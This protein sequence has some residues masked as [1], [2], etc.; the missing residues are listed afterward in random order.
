MVVTKEEIR[1]LLNKLQNDPNN[2]FDFDYLSDKEKNPFEWKAILEGSQGSIYENGY[3]M[4]KIVF[5][6]SYPSSCPSVYF[7]NKIFHPHIH[8]SGTACIHPE[9]N[10]ILSVMECVENMF[11]YYDADLNHA[12]GEEPRTTLERNKEEFI[13]KAQEWVRQYA[14]LEDL[15]KFYDL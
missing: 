2:R 1:T 10:D 7:L 9:R 6:E 4:V 3:Y 12:Y 13:K 11:F 14:K 8:S 5:N 15:D